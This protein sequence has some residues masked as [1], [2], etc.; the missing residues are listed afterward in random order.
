MKTWVKHIANSLQIDLRISA[1]QHTQADDQSLAQ[2]L[3]SIKLKLRTQ[4]TTKCIPELQHCSELYCKWTHA[5]YKQI[6][7]TSVE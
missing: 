4:H 6:Q 2:D 3:M 5:L 1:N 7:L